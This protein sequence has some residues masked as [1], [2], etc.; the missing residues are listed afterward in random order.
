MP[1]QLCHHA[2]P[3]LLPLLKLFAESCHQTIHLY[4]HQQTKVLLKSQEQSSIN[5]HVL[6]QK[7][8]ITNDYTWRNQSTEFILTYS[9]TDFVTGSN[10]TRVFHK[11][12]ELNN[13]TWISYEAIMRLYR[14]RADCCWF[15][16]I[17]CRMA[18]TTTTVAPPCFWTIQP[19]LW[20]K[21]QYSTY[22]ETST[23]TILQPFFKVHFGE[24]VLSQR[25]DLLEQPLDSYELDVLPA[26]QHYGVK[27]LQENPVV[28]SSFVFTV[29]MRSAPHV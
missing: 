16:V 1:W 14:Q 7:L 26:A 2:T 28:W 22:P 5:K 9:T 15:A 18:A 12:L 19:T 13:D 8:F 10:K 21:R 23:T 11:W 25:R 4:N 24:P 6:Q 20:R 17:V 3:Q 29:M 27:A